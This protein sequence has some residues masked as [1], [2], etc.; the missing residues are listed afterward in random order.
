MP[1]KI[2]P[3]SLPQ[4][5]YLVKLWNRPQHTGTINM[6]VTAKALARKGYVEKAPGYVHWFNPVYKLTQA[7]IRFNQTGKQIG[8]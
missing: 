4:Q 3:L 6:T 5:G 2:A 8:E 1:K 7:G